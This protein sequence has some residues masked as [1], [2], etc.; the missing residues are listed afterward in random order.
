MEGGTISAAMDVLEIPPDRA[1]EVARGLLD[2]VLVGAPPLVVVGEPHPALLAALRRN[3]G[4][5]AFLRPRA[6]LDRADRAAAR[7][8]QR[9]T[10]VRLAAPTRLPVA[11][12]GEVLPLLVPFVTGSAL[13]LG[14]ALDAAR[15]GLRLCEVPSDPAVADGGLRTARRLADVARLELA[16]R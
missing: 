1:T 16:R 12:K 11:C 5:V 6:G 3:E 10:G 15:A 13:G 9:L 7:A 8:L 14:V 2:R 4:D